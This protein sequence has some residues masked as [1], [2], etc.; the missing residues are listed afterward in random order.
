MQ[1]KK[2]L[3]LVLVA[4]IVLIVLLLLLPRG[5][6]GNVQTTDVPYN[7]LFIRSRVELP[8]TPEQWLRVYTEKYEVDYNLAYAIITCESGWQRYVQ[9]STSSA[10]GYWQFINGTWYSTM[11][12]MGYPADTSK[13]DFPLALEAGVFLL[14]E[15]GV[16]HWNESR[17]CWVYAL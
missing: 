14:S 8:K 5:S 17:F 6:A 3:P 1:P 15:D 11:L 2:L 9:N 7:E 12:R 16:G 4:S 10:S 13:Y